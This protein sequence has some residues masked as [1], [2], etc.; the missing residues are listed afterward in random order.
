LG[1]ISVF[2]L[3]FL[4]SFVTFA[5]VLQPVLAKSWIEV[6]LPCTISQGGNYRIISSW[7][8]TGT[9]LIINATDVVVDGQNK[10][11]LSDGDGTAIKITNSS[12][13]VLLKNLRQKNANVGLKAAGDNFTVQDSQFRGNDKYG[14]HANS[15]TNFKLKTVCFA[16]MM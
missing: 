16:T 8:G 5:V 3:I 10:L 1:K 6:T 9:A 11:I 7:T 2:V 12:E 13:N 4:L 14:I 15:C